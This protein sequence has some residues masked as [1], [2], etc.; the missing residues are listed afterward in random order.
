MTKRRQKHQE[1]T[2]SQQWEVSISICSCSSKEE[3]QSSGREEGEKSSI[4]G[5][6]SGLSILGLQIRTSIIKQ[7]AM[8]ASG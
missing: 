7:E 2:E 4:E 3:V 1:D 5:E 6:E 8:S